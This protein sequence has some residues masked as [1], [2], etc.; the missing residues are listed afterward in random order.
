MKKTKRIKLGLGLAALGRPEYI[1]IGTASQDDKTETVMKQIAYNVLDEAYYGGIRYFDTAP[2]YG[3][4]EEFL[5]QW[6]SERAHKDVILGTKWGY[7][8]V[9]DWKIGYEGMH[10][11]KEHSI[12]KLKEQWEISKKLLPHLNNYQIHSA[13]LESGVLINEEVLNYLAL[14]KEEYD[15][16]IGI[17]T[18]GADQPEILEKAS[19]IRLNGNP[20]FDSFQVTYNVLEYSTHRVLQQLIAKGKRVIIK[21]A[22]A[23]GRLLPNKEYQ[24]YRDLY[25]VLTIL[26][27]KYQVGADAIALR[28]CMDNLHP[29]FVLSG[30]SSVNYLQDNLKV[31]DFTLHSEDIELLKLHTVPSL[32][33]WSERGKL[34]WN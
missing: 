5:S 32:D 26:S 15:I 34:K 11:I 1:N 31:H 33:Y 30:A 18:S 3:K 6:N 22:L 16:C 10:E 9:A 2:S 24:H 14:L 19:S 4:G 29:E 28:F 13:T 20:L 12:S 27:D 17:T 21:E 8:Y 23:N 7:T 25:S